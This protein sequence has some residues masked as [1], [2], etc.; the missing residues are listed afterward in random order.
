MRH[1]LD[2][3]EVVYRGD[4]LSKVLAHF[5]LIKW[6]DPLLDTFFEAFLK[7]TSAHVGTDE[8]NIVITSI[9]DDFERC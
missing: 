2:F 9:I 8:V 1:V 7:A 5:V 4:E 3:M 6:L